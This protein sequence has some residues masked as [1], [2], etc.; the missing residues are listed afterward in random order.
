MNSACTFRDDC[1][2][3][4]VLVSLDSIIPATSFEYVVVVNFAWLMNFGRSGGQALTFPLLSR[5]EFP[6]TA[7]VVQGVADTTHYHGCDV[8]SNPVTGTF[9]VLLSASNQIVSQHG[10]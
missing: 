10:G 6:A 5:F 9:F 8:S 4:N 3:R 7:R 2:I 1:R